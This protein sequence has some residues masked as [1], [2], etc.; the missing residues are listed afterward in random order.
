MQQVTFPHLLDRIHVY[1]MKKYCD[2]WSLHVPK[3]MK[4]CIFLFLIFNFIFSHG[5]FFMLWFGWFVW[6]LAMQNMPVH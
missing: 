2:T 5:N 6:Y 4:L 1:F 3:V